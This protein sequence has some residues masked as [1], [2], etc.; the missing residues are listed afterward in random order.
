MKK[1]KKAPLNRVA[2]S[3]FYAQCRLK[4]FAMTGNIGWGSFQG[5]VD[6]S[7]WTG[8]QGAQPIHWERQKYV[9]ILEF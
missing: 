9:A 1:K 8:I 5:A 7:R 2:F 6:H 4:Q 3:I